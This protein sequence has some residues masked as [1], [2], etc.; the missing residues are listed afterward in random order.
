MAEFA[1]K[2]KQINM[3]EC[4]LGLCK[5][6]DHTVTGK[7]ILN[8]GEEFDYA[9]LMDGH[10]IDFFINNMRQQ[11]WQTIMCAD[12]P[13]NALYIILET[14]HIV[15][16]STIKYRKYD[17][18]FKKNTSGSTLLMMRAFVD[19]IET[20]SV[21]DSQIVIFKNG[22]YEYGSLPHNMRN[23]LEVERIAKHSEYSH[24]TKDRPIPS[25]RNATSLQTIPSEYH[26]FKDSTMLAMT[27]AIGHNNI[28]G[29]DPEKNIVF[30]KEDDNIDVIM[31][32][33]GLW[34]MI[35]LEQT[36]NTLHSLTEVEIADIAQDKA[37]LLSMNATE[38]VRKAE[39]RW[40]K[41][42]W[43]FHWDINDF[44]KITNGSFGG[45]YDDISVVKWSKKI[46]E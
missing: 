40:Q 24:T 20:L 22:E 7:G 4:V 23:P 37:D 32:S 28:T 35:L 44:N 41:E 3:T 36:A 9:V 34:E 26:H 46:V 5:N 1:S 8:N 38:L 30:F 13:W 31:G 14:I 10:G 39:I 45:I 2:N 42:D 27:Q 29:Y 12:D 15:D 43:I 21:G 19:R 33:D 11:D 18:V 17:Y 16:I 6:Q 25:I